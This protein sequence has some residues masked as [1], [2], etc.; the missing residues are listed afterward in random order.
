MPLLPESWDD[1]CHYQAQPFTVANI[2]RVAGT[3]SKANK[4]N[5]QTVKTKLQVYTG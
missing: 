1:R 3:G 4:K 5:N 2:Y